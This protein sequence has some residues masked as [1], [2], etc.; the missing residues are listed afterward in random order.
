MGTTSSVA[1]D[2][3]EAIASVSKKYD[4]WLH[5]DAAYAGNAL[6]LPEFRKE[7][8]SLEGADSFVFNPHKWMFT[9]FDLSAYYVKDKEALINTFSILP[10]YLR[11][12]S[13][14]KVNDYRDWGIQ[15]G[16]RFRALK[17]C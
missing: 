13:Y 9:N 12:A 6:I 8:G 4:C 2:P 11:T 15:L 7:I 17:R 16:R 3:I 14:G 1:I 10:E 5:I